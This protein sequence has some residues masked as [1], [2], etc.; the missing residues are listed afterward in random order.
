MGT[1]MKNCKNL[2]PLDAFEYKSITRC[3]D[4]PCDAY[5]M[6]WPKSVTRPLNAAFQ[7]GIYLPVICKNVYENFTS[8]LFLPY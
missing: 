2:N 5:C 6:L 1:N 4:R 3:N 7:C 8:S